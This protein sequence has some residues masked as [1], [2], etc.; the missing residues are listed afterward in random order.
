MVVGARTLLD[1]NLRRLSKEIVAAEAASTSDGALRVVEHATDR[2]AASMVEV[3]GRWMRTAE[4][5]PSAIAVLARVNSLLL[6]PHVA[7]AEAGVPLSSTVSPTVFERTGMRAALAYLRIAA[8]AD[9]IDTRDILEVLR[10]PTR[11][12]PPWFSDRLEARVTWSPSQVRGIAKQ[13]AT[14]EASKVERLASD[15]AAVVAAARSGTT[16]DVLEVVRDQVG[17]G[18]AMTLLDR[19]G[20]GQGS[21]HLDDIEA[22][23]EVADL[24]PE[25]SGFET[26][27]RSVVSDPGDAGG[28]TLSTIHRVKGREWT[29]VA[30]FGVTEGIMPHRLSH[31]L[32]E[33]RRVLHVGITRGAEQVVVLGDRERPSP[34]LAEMAG[35]AP[36]PRASS[37]QTTGVGAGATRS[38]KGLHKAAPAEGVEAARGRAIAVLGGYRGVVEEVDAAG[39]RIRMDDGGS[40]TVRFGERVEHDGRR[41]PLVAPGDLWGAAGDAEKL[42]RSWRTEQA[43]STGK[44][45]YTVLSDAHLRGIALARPRSAEELLACDGI[46]PTKLDRYGDELIALL[47]QID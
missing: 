33:E 22:L 27:L 25:V 12:L 43:R 24:H 11:G 20:G 16:R 2:A 42:L 37:R 34:F 31:D 14:K 44:P 5:E 28:V 29:H 41:A 30:V 35:T 4:V 21:S 1:Y 45:A 10:R 19:T 38:K 39:A 36:R 13:V 40:L 3:V 15:L 6:A 23:M 47:D 17:L 7:L 8:A 18:T 46:G 9:R 26:W 32:E